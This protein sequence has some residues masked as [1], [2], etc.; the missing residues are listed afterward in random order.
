MNNND[1]NLYYARFATIKCCSYPF[2]FSWLFTIY[3]IMILPTILYYDH[4]TYL[5]F[6][7]SFKFKINYKNFKQAFYVNEF[8]ILLYSI[9]LKETDRWKDYCINLF[10]HAEWRKA[11]IFVL[12]IL[13]I[14]ISSVYLFCWEC[15]FKFLL[16][17]V[18][19]GYSVQS[20]NV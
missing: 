7:L 3:I 16:T 18:I 19:L 13:K 12:H 14:Y 8:Y 6:H 15:Y 10:I 11:E 2:W 5:I 4:V 20:F 17:E 9:S 1:D